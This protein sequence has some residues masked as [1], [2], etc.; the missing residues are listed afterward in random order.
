MDRPEAEV[1]IDAALVRSLLRAQCP[2]LA[3]LPLAPLAEGWD[4]VL[5]RAGEDWIVRLPRRAVA[6]DLV[7]GEQ[8][9]LPELA[10]RLPLP[11]PVPHHAGHPGEGYP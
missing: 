1:A 4:N 11:I 2:E 9:W 6:A 3:D 8:R 10:P 7:M 5:F